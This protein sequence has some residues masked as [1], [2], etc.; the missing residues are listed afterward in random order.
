MNFK[1]VLCLLLCI[2]MAAAVL[3]LGSLAAK[4]DYST[5]FSDGEWQM[6]GLINDKRA[7]NGKLPLSFMGILQAASDMRASE[8]A[9]M[10]STSPVR[11]NGDPW[12]YVLSDLSFSYAA[13]EVFEQRAMNSA[14]AELIFNA[15]T[16]YTDPSTGNPTHLNNMIDERFVHFGSAFVNENGKDV[17]VNI[18][19]ECTVTEIAFYNAEEMPHVIAGRSIED[20]ELMLTLTCEHGKSYVPVYESMVEGYDKHAPG[21]QTVTVKYGGL[22]IDAEIYVDFEDVKQT[23][24]YY[25]A[26]KDTV[27]LGLFS[28]TSGTTFSP[29][30]A[31]TRA[32]F[33]TVLAQCKGIDPSLYT[34]TP[35]SDVAAGKWYA[36]YVT[37][38]AKSAIATGS[39]DGIF[40]PSRAI[41]RQEICLMLYKFIDVEGK[42]DTIKDN[43]QIDSFGDI[44]MISGWAGEAVDYC[45]KKGFV[46][47]NSYGFF[48]PKAEAT[49]AQCAAIILAYVNAAEAE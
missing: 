2:V 11:P 34:E 47:G 13:P 30:S 16:A 24:W 10:G 39:G 42:K 20:A 6:Y 23:S 48:E 4:Y 14:N 28:G 31:M 40:S 9:K 18:F 7:E 27:E 41:T 12:H 46:S 43:A 33:V 21:K 25:G 26:V 32:M 15:L 29:K 36:P 37:W 17:W 5:I 19:T 3:P 8:I 49:R 1:R 38:A 44:A 35:F 22:S 45:R